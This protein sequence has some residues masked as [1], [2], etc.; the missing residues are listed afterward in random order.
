MAYY[1]KNDRTL[2]SSWFVYVSNLTLIDG[3]Q[4]IMNTQKHDSLII[5]Q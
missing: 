4:Q 1:M 5:K 3:E 2:G